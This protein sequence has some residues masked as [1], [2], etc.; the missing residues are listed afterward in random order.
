MR[1]HLRCYFGTEHAARILNEF[2]S[3]VVASS[4]VSTT[5]ILNTTVKLRRMMLQR[6]DH[7]CCIIVIETNDKQDVPSRIQ[8]YARVLQINDTKSV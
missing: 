4:I 2:S 8:C 7:K 3:R 1:Q 5:L 6:P